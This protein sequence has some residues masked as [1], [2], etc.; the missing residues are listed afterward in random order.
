MVVQREKKRKQQRKNRTAA[1]AVEQRNLMSATCTAKPTVTSEDTDLDEP[2]AV[3]PPRKRKR[4]LP[5]PA[6]ASAKA[7]RAQTTTTASSSVER[8]RASPDPLEAPVDLTELPASP[9]PAPTSLPRRSNRTSH[10]AK[11]RQSKSTT[12]SASERER[13]L[14]V[15]D[16]IWQQGGGDRFADVIVVER[17]ANKD[18]DIGS[19]G[20]GEVDCEVMKTVLPSGEEESEESEESDGKEASD[21][22]SDEP[23][24]SLHAVYAS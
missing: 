23:S 17:E 12:P 10:T 15:D 13:S 21:E 24:M 1:Q 4:V 7:A 2:D 8:A 16:L 6:Y 5:T 20:E 14:N 22:E 11:A 9:T 19:G 18:L 3:L